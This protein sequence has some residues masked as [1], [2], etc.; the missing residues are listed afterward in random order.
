MQ[1]FDQFE[2]RSATLNALQKMKYETPTPIQAQAIPALL[3][4]RDLI[5]QARTGTGK[6]AAFGVPMVDGAAGL[7]EPG[8]LGLILVPTRELALQVTEELA[9]I[10][11]GTPL[12]IVP[13]YGGVGMGAQVQ[14]LRSRSP[15]VVVATP[16]RLLDHLQQGNARLDG[17]RLL[18]LDEADRMLDMGF[19]PD[20]ERI[21]GALPRDRQ[22]ALFSATVPDPIKKLSLRF[23]H[24]PTMIRTEEG[25]AVTP[26]AEQFLV[27]V[28]ADR[29]AHALQSLLEKEAP[30]RAIV[31]TRTK[32]RARSLARTLQRGGWTAVALQGNMT[33]GQRERALSTFR[34]GEARILVATDVA[35]RGLDVPEVG[36]VIN[37][38]LPDEADAYVHRVGRTARLHRKGRAFSLVPPNERRDA[39]GIERATG[40]QMAPYELA[41]PP[42]PTVPADATT[43]PA[44]KPS[45]APAGRGEARGPGR[46]HRRGGQRRPRWN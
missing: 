41:L 23:M 38:D 12:R 17:V 34:G 24:Q 36:H 43:F 15:L 2:L 46:P 27:E 21:I 16:G 14:A 45:R 7:N 13:V 44:V 9:R 33:Q 11:Q 4:G 42:P 19:L 20:V 35:S 32:H 5:A 10:A 3:Q 8:V 28:P 39:Q 30:E 1:R 26:Q 6:T 29:K 22:T 37:Y 31:F 25:P 40:V 18:V